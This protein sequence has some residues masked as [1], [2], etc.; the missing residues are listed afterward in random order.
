MVYNLIKG[1]YIF[2][3]KSAETSPGEIINKIVHLENIHQKLSEINQPFRELIEKCLV[4]D[5]NKRTS[6]IDEL[7][8]ILKR[9]VVAPICQNQMLLPPRPKAVHL[10]TMRQQGLS[11]WMNSLL[12]TA[13]Q[14]IQRFFLQLD[15]C[16]RPGNRKQNS[17][18]NYYNR[19]R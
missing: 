9:A 4:V 5:A 3:G 15:V 8:S 10:P 17:R 12:N 7:I 16:K 14:K 19:L 11:K 18:N 2:G 6:D 13:Q 1:E